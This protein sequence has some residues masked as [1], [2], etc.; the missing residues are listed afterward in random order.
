[1]SKQSF[2]TG[3][4]PY[5]A[6]IDLTPYLGRAVRLVDGGIQFA[7]SGQKPFGVVV[8]GAPEGETATIAVNGSGAIVPVKLTAPAEAGDTL[9]CAED[10]MMPFTTPD[11]WHL[12]YKCAIALEDIA[13]NG[14]GLAVL[15][16]PTQ[17]ID[18]LA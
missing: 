15:I 16:T 8:V 7:G 11:E 10:G 12:A 9:V 3:L 14:I 5:K 4:L 13:F 17:V 2:V 1:M 6:G 18:P